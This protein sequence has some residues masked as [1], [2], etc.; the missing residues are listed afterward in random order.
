MPMLPS[1]CMC[2]KNKYVIDFFV[3][4][5]THTHKERE[6][7]RGREKTRG[8]GREGEA[9]EV[10]RILIGRL[11]PSSD[12]GFWALRQPQMSVGAAYQQNWQFIPPL[13]MMDQT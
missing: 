3:K 4:P 6:K 9:S 2:R 11:A 7:E 8:L 5:H 10:P 12:C 1:L 13:A